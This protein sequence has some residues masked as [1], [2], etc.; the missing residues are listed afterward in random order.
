MKLCTS[1]SPTDSDICSGEF[2]AFALCLGEKMFLKVQDIIDILCEG[3]EEI[4]LLCIL[5]T[6]VT[7]HQVALK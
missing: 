2:G 3:R 6:A 7:E 1:T 4:K 5:G